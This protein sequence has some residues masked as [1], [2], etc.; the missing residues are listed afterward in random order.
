M[1]KQVG[2]H[3]LPDENA[4]PAMSDKFPFLKPGEDFIHT[5]ILESP[6]TDFTKTCSPLYY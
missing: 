2:F 3:N 4:R 5:F 1:E 6:D